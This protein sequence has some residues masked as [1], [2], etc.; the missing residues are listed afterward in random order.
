MAHLDVGVS[1]FKFVFIC[2]VPLHVQMA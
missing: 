2:N 1:H